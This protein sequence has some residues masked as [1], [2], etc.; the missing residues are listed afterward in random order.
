MLSTYL[1]GMLE[2]IKYRFCF[3]LLVLGAL[4]LVMIYPQG[5]HKPDNLDLSA[6]V[7]EPKNCVMVRGDV[8]HPGIYYVGVNTMA[9]SVIEMAVPN[10]G[11]T[12]GMLGKFANISLSNGNLLEV[13]GN[14]GSI[15]LTKSFIPVAERL[16]LKIPLDIFSMTEADFDLLPGVGSGLAHRITEYRQNNGGLLR[17]EDLAKVEGIG[18]KKFKILYNYFR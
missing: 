12:P 11:F 1:A 2:D 9:D 18:D 13:T 15:V 16:M 10:A 17:V 4:V 6:I 5:S 8:V 14:N 3:V 7:A